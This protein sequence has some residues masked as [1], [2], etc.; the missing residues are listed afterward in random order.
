MNEAAYRQMTGYTDH[1]LAFVIQYR[2]PF[3]D[4]NQQREIKDY[5][6]QV[7][8]LDAERIAYL[9]AER[10]PPDKKFWKAHCSRCGSAKLEL[11]RYKKSC[12]ICGYTTSRNELLR[13]LNDLLSVLGYT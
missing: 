1:E 3:L 13:L 6:Q 8:K 7:R 4:E 11:E 2:V 12:Q 9:V 5:V 10:I